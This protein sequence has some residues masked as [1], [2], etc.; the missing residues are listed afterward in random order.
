MVVPKSFR[1][2]LV[3]FVH[4]PVFPGHLDDRRLYDTRQRDYFWPHLTNDG[5]ITVADC[6]SCGAQ[7]MRTP[8]S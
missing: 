6:Q 3:F 5:Y 4:Y 8:L 1:P 2:C 7:G